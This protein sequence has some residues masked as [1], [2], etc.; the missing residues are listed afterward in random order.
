MTKKT[1]KKL[2]IISTILAAVILVGTVG[3]Y[4]AANVA[5]SK[6]T[7][8]VGKSMEETGE[9]IELPVLDNNNTIDKTKHISVVLDAATMKKLESKVSV[10]DK[11]A[12]MGI[13]AK[14]LSAE[15]YQTLLSYAVGGVDNKK[16]KA[17]Y[18]LIRTRL[19]QEQK[20]QIKSYYAKYLHLLEE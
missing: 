15:D 13:L 4:I 19:G 8:T 7:E 20:D 9:A 18:E 5:F 17:A 10:S 1:K 2:L 6:I 3:T 11:L 12:V 14:S 16:F